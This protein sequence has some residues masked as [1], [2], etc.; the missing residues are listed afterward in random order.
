MGI[1]GL[2]LDIV[3]LRRIGAIHAR[4]GEPFILRFCRPGEWQPRQGAALI[5]HIGG[6]FAAKEAVMKAIGSGWGKGV[7]FR[8]IEVVRTADGAPSV[9]LHAAAAAR[10]NGLGVAHIHLSI[11]HERSYAAAVAVLEG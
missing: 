2:G 9:R 6:L 3:D 8:Q 10:A 4:R 11:T 5:E 7:G 1:I